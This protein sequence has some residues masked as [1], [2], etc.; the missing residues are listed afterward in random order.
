VI[1]LEYRLHEWKI[2][3]GIT[4]PKLGKD[5]YGKAKSCRVISHLNYIRKTVEKVAAILITEAVENGKSHLHMGQLGG[6]KGR[7]AID[8]SA[9]LIV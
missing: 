1:R 2:A 5:D 7:G 9:R 8:A 4:I 3:K 6:R